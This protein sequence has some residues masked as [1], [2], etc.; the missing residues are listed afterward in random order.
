[1]NLRGSKNSCWRYRP[2]SAGGQTVQ[3]GQKIKEIKQITTIINSYVKKHPLKKV[4]LTTTPI[5]VHLNQNPRSKLHG[6]A[7]SGVL[8][9]ASVE[10]IPKK[11]G[12][13]LV[14]EKKVAHLNLAY[15]RPIE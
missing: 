1:M 15:I 3:P 11:R 8:P 13:N 12:F 2:P 7:L 9:D 4:T 10:I 14:T 6:M 5:T